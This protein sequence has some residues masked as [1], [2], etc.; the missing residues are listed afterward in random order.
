M[1]PSI[2]LPLRSPIVLVVVLG[3]SFGRGWGRGALLQNRC[4]RKATGSFCR[5]PGGNRERARARLGLNDRGK[6]NATRRPVPTLKQ[7]VSRRQLKESTNEKLL[8]AR[9]T[10]RTARMA[11]SSV[12]FSGPLATP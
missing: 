7:R 1:R 3:S 2:L 11:A 5:D 8:N 6:K 10:V 9:K 4:E 12:Y